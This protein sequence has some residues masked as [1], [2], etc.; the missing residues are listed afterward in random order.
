MGTNYTRVETVGDRVHVF[1]RAE[2]PRYYARYHDN[3]G[4]RNLKSLKTTNLKQARI[5][6]QKIL[7]SLEDNTHDRIEEV[8][9]H[10]QV[11]L[12][13]QLMTTSVNAPTLP[14]HSTRRKK[15]GLYLR[16]IRGSAQIP[17]YPPGAAAYT[18]YHD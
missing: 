8:C 9:V 17:C 1:K 3:T 10:R 14:I 15:L 2:R 7:R 16:R 12:R 5:N 11:S 6:A 18:I 4:K 13:M